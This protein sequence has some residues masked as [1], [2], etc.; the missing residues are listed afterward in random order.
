MNAAAPRQQSTTMTRTIQTR[1]PPAMGEVGRMSSSASSLNASSSTSSSPEPD[2]G[3]WNSGSNVFLPGFGSGTP[4]RLSSVSTSM[5]PPPLRK[6]VAC[7]SFPKAVR[8]E[9]GSEGCVRTSHPN[10]LLKNTFMRNALLSRGT[11]SYFKISPFSR[12]DQD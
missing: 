3:T 6:V 8:L 12:A 1:Y 5:G 2:G 9:T 4:R 7:P 11:P 10:I